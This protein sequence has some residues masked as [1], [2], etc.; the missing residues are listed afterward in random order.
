VKEKNNRDKI[1]KWKTFEQVTEQLLNDIKELL[2]LSK[3]EFKKRKKGDATNW[4]VEVTAFDCVTE[5]L[6]LVECK[7]WAKRVNQET[8]GGFAYRIKDA[9][10]ER[11]IIVTASG[12]QK[13][14]N[15]IAVKEKIAH[16]VLQKDSDID[17][18]IAEFISNIFVKK[19]NNNL[20][21]L[22][23]TEI[24]SK[25]EIKIVVSGFSTEYDLEIN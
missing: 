1:K 4:S 6:V 14:A 21:S 8:M 7:C 13:G 17:N 18:Y 20:Q 11:G 12:L 23:K 15:K 9:G 25:K 10:A 24:K 2:G 22:L 5:R 3:I 19:T 16:I